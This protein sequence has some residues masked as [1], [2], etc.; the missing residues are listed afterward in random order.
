MVRMVT[1]IVLMCASGTCVAQQP[2]KVRVLTY[3]IHHGEGTDGKLDLERIAGVIR[4]VEPDVV[5]LQEVDR[6]TSRTGSVDQPE[7]LARRTG[8]RAIFSR[9]IAFGGGEYGNAVLTRWPVA[10]FRNVHLPLLDDGE[11]RGV[12]IVDLQP[13]GAGASV[14]FLATH[15]DHRPADGER[16][17]A[18]A[19]INELM[20][21]AAERPAILAGDLNAPPDSGVLRIV[22]QQWQPSSAQELPTMP[23]R[24]PRRQIDYVFT[25]PPGRWRV[26]QV[27]VLDEAVASDHRPLLAELEL[28]PNGRAPL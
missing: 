4:S 16:L 3:N 23:S 26:S 14:Q 28:L 8:M 13:P 17:A 2:L 21:A 7:E 6:G 22:L 27:R 20:Q 5:A 18:A 19:K 1:A 11:Q 15:W 24:A 12:L 25:R 10:A 9:N